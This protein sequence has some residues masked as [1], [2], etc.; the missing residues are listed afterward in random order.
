MVQNVESN[1]NNNVGVAGYRTLTD[2]VM[3][4][5]DGM[6][7]DMLRSAKA[8]FLVGQATEGIGFDGIYRRF[9]NVHRYVRAIR[10]RPETA[11]TTW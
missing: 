9:R 8:A 7:C 11:T 6:H 4:G 1:Q 2:K 5:T 10:R 3:L